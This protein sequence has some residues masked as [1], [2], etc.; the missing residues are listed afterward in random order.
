M[1]PELTAKVEVASAQ[2]RGLKTALVAFSGGVDSSLVLEIA[3]AA[4]G[5]RCQGVIA[6]SPSLPRSEL[7]AALELASK[8][9][10]NVKVLLTDEVGRADY[11][12]NTPQRCFFCKSELYDRLVEVAAEVGATVLDGFNRDDRADWRPGRRAAVERGVLSPLDAAGM[13]K[14]EVRQAARELGLSNWDKPAA[15][16]LSSRIPY[17]VPVTI[18]TLGRVE[19]AEQ[20]LRDE[21][22]GQLRVRDAHAAATIEVEPHQLD[23]IRQPRRLARIERRLRELG[24]ASVAVDELGYRRGSLNQAPQR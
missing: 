15:A 10:W 19:S 11:A 16:C 22:F 24:Y 12:A 2:V 13:G 20:V 17:G 8:R 9:G 5:S 18:E 21:G 1:R 14:D 6:S 7:E 3:T 23:R 4:L